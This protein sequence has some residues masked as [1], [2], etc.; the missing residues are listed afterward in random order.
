MYGFGNVDFFALVSE[1]DASWY[2]PLG[3]STVLALRG[4]YGTMLGADGSMP[5]GKRFFLGGGG[6]V[7]GFEHQ[8]IGR[9][10]PN[11]DPYGGISYL[12]FNSEIRQYITKDFAVVPFMDGGMVYDDVQPDFSEKLAVGA[13]IGFRYNTPVGPVR[14]DIAVPLTSAYRGDDKDITDFQLYISIGQAF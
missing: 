14:L 11:D 2:L 12:L 4:A 13:G 10:D 3:K 9:H 6:S 8:E 1:L 5:R 7:R